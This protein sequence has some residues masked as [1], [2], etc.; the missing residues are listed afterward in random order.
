VVEGT[1]DTHAFQA[2]LEPDG[3]GSHWLR[4]SDTMVAPL[5]K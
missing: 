5:G 2:P 3:M 4:V 1:F